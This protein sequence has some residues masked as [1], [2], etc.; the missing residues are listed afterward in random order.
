MSTYHIITASDGEEI[1][2]IKNFDALHYWAQEK[3][4]FIE[5]AEDYKRISLTYKKLE[6]LKE[7]IKEN[8]TGHIFLMVNTLEKFFEEEN[9]EKATLDLI[10]IEDELTLEHPSNFKVYFTNLNTPV[11]HKML[12]LYEAL[13]LA[14]DKYKLKQNTTFIYEISI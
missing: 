2:N 14:L 10:K 5:Q 1:F 9:L 12:N 3:G 7:D 11:L 8:L 6:E 13:I 4:K